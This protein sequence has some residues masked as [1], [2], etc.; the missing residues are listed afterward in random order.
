MSNK[1]VIVLFG[2]DAVVGEFSSEDEYVL[3]LRNVSATPYVRGIS[4]VAAYGVDEKL[5]TFPCAVIY[6]DKIQCV[7]EC[8]SRATE[9]IK[10]A[11]AA[12]ESHG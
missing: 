6:K 10:K 11:Q 5:P 4:I 8:S 9:S 1:Y 7:L 2:E 3:T 12:G